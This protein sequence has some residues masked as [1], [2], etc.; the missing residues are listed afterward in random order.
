[1]GVCLFRRMWVQV[2]M[3]R[4]INPQKIGPK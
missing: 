2:G 3:G 1:M 4:A